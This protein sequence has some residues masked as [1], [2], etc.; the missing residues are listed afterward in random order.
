[1]L[2]AAFLGEECCWQLL[3]LFYRGTTDAFWDEQLKAIVEP[4]R[5]TNEEALAKK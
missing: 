1:M 3:H 4:V 5:L 2:S